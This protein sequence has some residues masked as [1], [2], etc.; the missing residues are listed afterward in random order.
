MRIM[1]AVLL[2]LVATSV[3]GERAD[4]YRRVLEGEVR[5]ELGLSGPVAMFAA[6]I[7]QESGWNE[8]ARSKYAS[9]LTQFTP[10]TVD[11]VSKKFEDE[12][13]GLTLKTPYWYI[14]AMVLYDC[15]LYRMFPRS[16]SCDRWAFAL[17]SYNG[18]LGWIRK[19]QVKARDQ[20][21]DPNR[22][23]SSVEKVTVRALWAKKENTGYPI[24]ILGKHQPKYSGWGPMVC[25]DRHW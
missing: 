6:Q 4:R 13:S 14:R 1:L 5:R 19:E 25:S 24:V 12:L 7:H 18:G 23:W 20:G 3:E 8:N 15:Y 11:W 16:E 17:A 21:L 9:G 10:D 2:L 22:Y